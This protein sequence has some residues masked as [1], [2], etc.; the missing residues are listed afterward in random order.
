MRRIGK[1]FFSLTIFSLLLIVGS[2]KNGKNNDNENT[3][4]DSDSVDV[5]VKMNQAKEIFY[6]LPA[7]HEVAM[8]LIQ[9]EDSYFDQELLSDVSQ[10]YNYTTEASKAYNLGV[11]SADLSYAS[12][13]DQNQVVI[14]YMATTKTIAEQLGI[15]DAFD[16]ETIELLEQNVN[17][18]DEVMKIISESF[19]DS[20]AYLQ[21]NDRHEIGAMIL[22]GGWIEGVYLAVMLSEKDPLNNVPLTSSIL[23]QQLSLELMVQFLNDFDETSTHLGLMKTDMI[24]L[25]EVYNSLETNVTDDGYLTVSEEEFVKICTKIENLRKK[26]IALS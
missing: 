19:M 2:C 13:F 7:P 16:Q 24:D 26:I 21:E 8:F 3:V 14:N 12:L 25:Y 20:D 15:L 5:Q 22:I 10:S 1:I 9:N 17:D 6:S 11:Y 18:R 23:E 4:I